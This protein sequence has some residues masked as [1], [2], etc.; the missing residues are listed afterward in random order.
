MIG[1]DS[2]EHG[3]K[4]MPGYSLDKVQGVMVTQGRDD[5]SSCPYVDIVGIVDIDKW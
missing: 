3:W 1:H 4:L 2:D 5:K